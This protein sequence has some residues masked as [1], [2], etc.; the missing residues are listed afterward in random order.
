MRK[1]EP[2]DYVLFAVLF[3]AALVP[4][5]FVD[6]LGAGG[7][8]SLVGN[9]RQIIH[10]E[11]GW[12]NRIG[13]TLCLLPVLSV[14]AAGLAWWLQGVAVRRGLG[15]TRRPRTDQA[16]DYDDEPPSPAPKP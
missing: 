10:G 2:P 7:E 4:L 6:L 1:S 11:H 8:R 12:Q 9:I 3:M 15:L 5:S 16:A 13:G 14:P